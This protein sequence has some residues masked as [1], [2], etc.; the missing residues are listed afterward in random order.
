MTVTA[1][2]R[3]ERPR[4]L[5]AAF[6]A[7]VALV[8]AVTVIVVGLAGL[9]V[10]PASAQP[11][12]GPGNAVG[13]F[14]YAG[15]QVVGAHQPVLAGQRRARAPSYDRVAVGS[16]VAA[17]TEPALAND[18]AQ[19][20]SANSFTAATPVLL[21]SGTETAISKIKIGDKV[22]ATDPQTNQTAA[23][24]VTGIIVHSGKHTMVDVILAD[25][26]KLTATDHHTFWDA[27]TSSFTFAIDLRPGDRVK[28]AMGELLA[29]T[30]AKASDE[31]VTAYNLTV[32]GI[33]T[34]YA[35][36]TPVLVHNSCTDLDTLSQSGETPDRNGFTQAG[37]A[38]QK[39][40]FRPG[41]TFAPPTAAGFLGDTQAP[42]VLNPLGQ[43]ALD[44]I[45]TDPR[46][47]IQSYGNTADYR[48]PWGGAR[49]VNDVLTGFLSP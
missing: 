17:E 44:D 24:P 33:H 42:A 48:L 22:L 20:C 43:S 1:S 4:R 39:H 14:G 25:G 40:F 11:L 23:R 6:R 31:F 46:T 26:S 2:A 12:T 10:S 5:P 27:T 36:T 34:Y 13:V 49:F 8:A 28:G 3:R 18:V 7:V 37:R 45:L 38:F 16:C 30:S 32:G 47:A 19:A 29:V 41:S 21:A 35:G 9:F 15:G